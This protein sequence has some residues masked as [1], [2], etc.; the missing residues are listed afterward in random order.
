MDL[1]N[2]REYLRTNISLSARIQIL[3]NKEVAIVK[4]GA[5]STLFR[6]S[7]H[8]N[9]IDEIIEHIPSGSQDESLYRF[10]QMVNNKLDFIID[11]LSLKK[12]EA[13]DFLV[14]VVEISGSGLKFECDRSLELGTLLKMDLIMPGSLL[15]KV[16]LISKV[17]RVEENSGEN[18][19][20][21]RTYIVAASFEKVEE[22]SRDEI[23]KTVFE[24]QRRIIRTEKMN[25]EE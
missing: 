2:K 5:G 10:Y 8:P 17:L 14:E 1:E 16:E 23:I 15:F 24:M 7:S 20:K 9:P 3:S 22:E 4:S 19:E 6:G 18:G 13:K 21:I 12:E 25:S 11:Q